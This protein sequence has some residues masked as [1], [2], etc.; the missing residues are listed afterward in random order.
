MPMLRFTVVDDKLYA[1]ERDGSFVRSPYDPQRR[2]G[3]LLDID[4]TATDPLASP[5]NAYVAGF[6]AAARIEDP[7]VLMVNGYD[8]DPT[9]LVDADPSRRLL[10]SNPHARIFH[11]DR[12]APSAEHRLHAAS[13]PL[14]LGIAAEDQAPGGAAIAVAWYSDH[15]SH[16][17]AYLDGNLAALGIVGVLRCLARALPGRKVKLLGHSLGTHVVLHTLRVIA[18]EFPALGAVV[19]R[20][21]L[22]GGSEFVA[23]ASRTCDSLAAAGLAGK[24]GIYNIGSQLDSVISRIS[25][26][27]TFGPEGEKFMIG[28]KGLGRGANLPGWIDIDISDTVREKLKAA[29]GVAVAADAPGDL[30]DHWYYFTLP[31]NMRFV[32]QLLRGG[33]NTSIA[34]LRQVGVPE[35][36]A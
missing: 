4:D 13:W 18:Q 7:I 1:P 36:I 23:Q 27:A 21:V 28:A 22:L 33:S 16:L 15:W 2:A 30:L 14:S 9:D 25:G 26:L 6:A 31:E 24:I 11:F 10:S 35:G 29:F 5:L 19:D 12:H 32:A 34:A 8:F 17:A 20:A 3:L